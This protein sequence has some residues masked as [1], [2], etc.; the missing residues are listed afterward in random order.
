M[1]DAIDIS[2]LSALPSPL[3][4][5]DYLPVKR[6]GVPGLFRTGISPVAVSG[7]YSDLTV[8]PNLAAVA[9]SGAYADLIGAPPAT[10]AT[11]QSSI[12]LGATPYTASIS[13][14]VITESSNNIA[15]T[16]TIAGNVLT[17]VYGAPISQTWQTTIGAGGSI[18]T[19]RTA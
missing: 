8:R 7:A 14:S 16:T 3:A 6:S 18:S 11:Q 5:G 12:V 13:G 2:L 1:A 15:I 9:T 10:T 17:A 19:V 4:P